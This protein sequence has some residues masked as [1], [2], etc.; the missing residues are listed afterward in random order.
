MSSRQNGTLGRLRDAAAGP[1]E[2]YLRMAAAVTS[3]VAGT[4]ARRASGDPFDHRDPEY[5]E[6]T[7]P[8]WRLVSD[9]YFRA[10]VTGLDNIPARGPALL[11]GNHSG[12]TLIADT[13]VFAQAFYD[14]FGPHRVFHQLA[15]DLVFKTP[16]ARALVQRY[17]TVPASPKNM[18]SALERDAALL[19]YPGGDHETFRPSWESEEVDFANRTGFVKLALEHNVPIVPVVA[20]GGQETALFLG[21]GSRIANTLGL[22]RLIRLKVFPAVLG[23]PFGVTILDL[24]LRFPLPAKISIRVLEPI[25]LRQR[26]DDEDDLE[27]AYELV[28]STMQEA[29]TELAQERTLPVI[30]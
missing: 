15:H 25:D 10:Q 21:Q 12:G 27:E 5:I 19:V 14:H 9:R 6:R 11:V 4:V 13:F 16:G 18:A 23:P 20:I 1:L 24:P 28:T 3:D 8:A 26:L 29:L 30:G 17:G 7:L 22:N 2:A